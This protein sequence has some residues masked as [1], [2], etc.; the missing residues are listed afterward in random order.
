MLQNTDGFLIKAT[1]QAFSGLIQHDCFDL[2]PESRQQF[3][4][5]SMVTPL[6]TI[7]CPLATVREILGASVIAQLFSISILVGNTDHWDEFV[8]ELKWNMAKQYVN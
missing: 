7:C 6:I 4:A 2:H 3:L 8:L 1:D 5:K